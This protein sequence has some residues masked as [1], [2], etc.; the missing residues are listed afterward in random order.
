MVDVSCAV[1]E[2]LGIKNVLEKVSLQW[3]AVMSYAVC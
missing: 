2:D 1:V 3:K